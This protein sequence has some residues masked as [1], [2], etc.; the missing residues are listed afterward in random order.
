MTP[1]WLFVPL[2][3]MYLYG[4]DCTDAWEQ[5]RQH[6]N[7]GGFER[8]IALLE[9]CLDNGLPQNEEPSILATL[10]QAQTALDRMGDAAETV[11]LL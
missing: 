1:R 11:A 10:A 8:V 2:T 5:A 4:A 3:I 7:E 9:P 6:F